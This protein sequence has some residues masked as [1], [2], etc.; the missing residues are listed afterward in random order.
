MRHLLGSKHL[1]LSLAVASLAVVFLMAFASGTA[2]AAGPA[3]VPPH[4]VNK[5]RM[6]QRAD[7]MLAKAEEQVHDA[8]MDHVVVFAKT[9]AKDKAQDMIQ[10]V[11]K[12]ILQDLIQDKRVPSPIMGPGQ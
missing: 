9:G 11:I 2:S 5:A 1:V 12:P 10:S 7:Q 3:G 6:E 4:H 8:I